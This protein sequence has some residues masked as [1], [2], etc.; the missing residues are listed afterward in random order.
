[1]KPFEVCQ[2][3][4]TENADL[5]AG[6]RDP[7]PGGEGRVDFLALAVVEK[8]L[9]SDVNHDV[10]ADNAEGRDETGQRQIPT[11]GHAS[12][13]ASGRTHMNR[14][15]DAER[16]MPQGHRGALPCFLNP[17]RPPH[18]EQDC[19]FSLASTIMPATLLVRS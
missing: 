4:G 13:A 17:H 8:T 6:K 10:I 1:M 5:A 7:M 9:Q 18:T 2:E 19:V 3:A 12:L 11:Y 14:L 16:S 15:P